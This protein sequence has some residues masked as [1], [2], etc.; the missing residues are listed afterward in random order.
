M[1][2]QDAAAAA[3]PGPDE[4]IGRVRQGLPAKAF[5]LLAEAL[6][7]SADR[8]ARLLHIAPRTLARRSIFKPDESDRILRLGCLF[9]RTCE[10]LGGETAA[11][12]WLQ[13]PQWALNGAMPLDLADTEPGAREVERLL[14][15]IEHGVVA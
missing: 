6:E 14:G 9:Q 11:R 5:D 3:L 10:V 8:L 4:L 1:R 15:R 12:A 2:L 7:V 13:T